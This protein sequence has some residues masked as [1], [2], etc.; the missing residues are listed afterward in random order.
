MKFYKKRQNY[1]D[2][3]KRSCQI[4]Q[5]IPEAIYHS[6]YGNCWDGSIDLLE[7]FYAATGGEKMKLVFFVVA[8]VF[9]EFNYFYASLK[10]HSIN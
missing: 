4:R 5:G 2:R 9:L 1:F 8:Q 3:F 7:I 6:N 10:T